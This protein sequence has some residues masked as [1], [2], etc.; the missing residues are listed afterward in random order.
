MKIR[1]FSG[2]SGRKF[3]VPRGKGVGGS[4]L[5]NGMIYT[6]GDKMDYKRWADLLNDSSW[7]YPHVL[8][9][10]KKSENF[11]KTNP[12]TPIDLNYHGYHG[13]LHMTESVP[14]QKITSKM[15]KGSEEMG[16]NLTDFNGKNTKGV[17]VFQVYTKDGWRFDSEMAF[18][19][20]VRHRNNLKVLDRSYVTK[21]KISKRTKRVEGVIFTKDNETYIARNRKEV[22]LSAGAISSP[23]ILML[24]GIGP[25]KPLKSLG[26]PVIQDLP[27]GKTLREHAAVP[28]VFSSNVTAYES[29]VDSAKDFV[30]GKGSFTR[31][32][33]YEFVGWMNSPM[34]K[35][36]DYPDIELLLSNITDSPL[37]QRFYGWS[38][39]TYEAL[40]VKVP[41][42]IV[43]L[44]VLLH[45]ESNGTIQ[46]RSTS[47]FD[48]PLIN[49]N[50]LSDK[51]NK[52]IETLYQGI[53]LVLDLIE[54]EAF[55]SMNITLALTQ[56]PACSHLKSWS[57]DYWYCYLRHLTVPGSH[58]VGTCLT[59]S[60]PKTG[61]V[62]K[63][64]RVFGVNG[65]R[66]ADASVVPITPTGHTN[67]VCTMVGEKIS[68]M[69]KKTYI[70]T[71]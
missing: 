58:Q 68:A 10:F 50:L 46:L 24:S 59:G 15:F 1:T 51:E 36:K 63:E 23:Q 37:S 39:E 54:T 49:P 9:Y 5:I 70:Y 31:P 41:N 71:C 25:Q 30:H 33:Q 19:S 16:Y 57:K 8:Q 28:L 2:F 52:D 21:I 45:S 27:V 66:V 26:I 40:N 56:L 11:T 60:S 17:S 55:R 35:N 44:V 22:I 12:F 47:P 61:V 3:N 43:I 42:P 69:I 34:E 6:R 38:D 67:A 48:Y 14:P 13:P 18:I 4:S 53:K 64:L 7:N 62:D 20:P 29:L 65:L 32:F